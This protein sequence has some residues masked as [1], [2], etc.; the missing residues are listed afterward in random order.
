MTETASLRRVYKYQF[1]LIDA[2]QPICITGFRKVVLVERRRDQPCLW[3]EVEP[4]SAQRTIILQVFGTGHDIEDHDLN[5]VGSFQ[6][7][8]FVFHVYIKDQS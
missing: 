6:A 4:S 3:V 8:M 5:H 2:P 1:D 7:G